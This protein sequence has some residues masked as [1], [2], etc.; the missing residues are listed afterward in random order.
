MKVYAKAL[1]I[2]LYNKSGKKEWRHGECSY[3]NVN[4]RRSNVPH[5]RRVKDSDA[6]LRTI[7]T[8]ISPY[9][10]TSLQGNN[11]ISAL[12]VQ[13]QDTVIMLQFQIDLQGRVSMR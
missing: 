3:C 8:D 5:T 2:T 1:N 6:P 12:A 4:N 9:Y 7:H 10:T 13:L 11:L